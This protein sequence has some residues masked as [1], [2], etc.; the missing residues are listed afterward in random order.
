MYYLYHIPGKKIGV[1]RDLKERVE[2]Q[3]GYESSEYGVLISTEDIDLVSRME[4]ELQKFYGYRVDEVPYN[5]LKFNNNNMNINITEMTTT[6]P[7]PV[8]KLK[9]RLIDE[10]GMQWETDSGPVGITKKS[11][12]WIM[13][14]VKTSQYTQDRCYIYNKA[15]ARWF[16]NHDAY[17]KHGLDN[18]K[19]MNDQYNG[20]TRSGAL[21]PSGM[22][23]DSYECCDENNPCECKE[24]I[25]PFTTFD[26]I[27]QWAFE[28]GLYE[29]GDVKTQ[30]LKLVEEV[31]ETCRAILKGNHEDA[32]DGIGDCVVVLTNLAELMDHPIEDCI[33]AAY[34]EI[35]NRTGK[36]VNGTFKKD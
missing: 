32:V 3:Q 33:D 12:G 14:N 1:T 36:M 25:P 29:K 9:G 34:Y 7:C 23:E 17:G 19:Q 30:A 5:K 26:N 2:R 18:A 8:N 31:G 13:D 24:N 4:I 11:I 28:R 16:D 21:S 6:F 35:K 20:R 22:N 27:R 10:I 15:F